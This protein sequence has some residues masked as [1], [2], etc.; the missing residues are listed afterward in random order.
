VQ[1]QRRFQQRIRQA[2]PAIITNAPNNNLGSAVI[3]G[4]L[5]QHFKVTTTGL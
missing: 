5:I 1:Q 3:D 4:L 2:T